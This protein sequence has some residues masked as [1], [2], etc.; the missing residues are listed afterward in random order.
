LRLLISLLI[1]VSLSA[2][3]QGRLE[4]VTSSGEHKIACETEY[5]WAPT[6]D[7]YAVEY[8]LTY[9]AKKAVAQ[10]H[11]VINESLLTLNT[12]ITLPPKG[13]KWTYELAESLHTSNQLT[14]KEFGYIIA[15]LDLG[16]DKKLSKLENNSD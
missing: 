8:I 1:G 11:T 2:C 14:D 6:V 5:T 9:C 13:K 7:K 3:T 10:G 15:Y 16:L 12:N 4:Y